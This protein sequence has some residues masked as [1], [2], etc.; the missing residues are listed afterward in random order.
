[1]IPDKSHD[2]SKRGA[3]L[4]A[5]AFDKSQLLESLI[6]NE[7]SGNETAILG[8][9]QVCFVLF[10]I[11]ERLDAFDQFKKI[12]V[13]LCSAEAYFEMHQDFY[14]KVFSKLQ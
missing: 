11:G 9:M 8:E 4:T 2:I 6:D 10:L 5:S 14:E 3:E 7:Y 1:M 13:L 12:F